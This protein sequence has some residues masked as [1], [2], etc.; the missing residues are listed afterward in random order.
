MLH[1]WSTA[2][3][4]NKYPEHRSS[5]EVIGTSR[6]IKTAPCANGRPLGVDKGNIILRIG[7]WDLGGGVG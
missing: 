4:H 5:P 7:G 2:V 6:G 3:R 1:A